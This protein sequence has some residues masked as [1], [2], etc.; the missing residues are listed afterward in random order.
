LLGRL[1]RLSDVRRIRG[2]QGIRPKGR[3]KETNDKKE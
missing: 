3:E 2:G 1:H